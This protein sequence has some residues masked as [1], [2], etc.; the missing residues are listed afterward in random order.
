MNGYT[1]VAA[2]LRKMRASKGKVFS[3][4][5]FLDFGSRASI[6]QALSRLS[7]SGKVRRVSR[8]LYDVPRKGTMV[9]V[10]APSLDSVADAM[11]RKSG[12]RMSPTGAQAANLLGLSKH[13]PAQARYLTDRRGRNLK[14]GKQTIRFDHAA[15]RR[16]AGTELSR[17]V[18]EALRYLGKSGIR[19][20]D[21]D[22]IGR[23]LADADRRAIGKASRTAPEWMRPALNALSEDV[24]E[25]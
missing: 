2:I 15:P 25:N 13:V 11:A 14:I 6:D 3:A 12:A 20:A 5:D 8:G 7:R 18:I 22:Q 21:I 10:R 16:L 19:S 24:H 4:V 17:T 1:V 23:R 9:A